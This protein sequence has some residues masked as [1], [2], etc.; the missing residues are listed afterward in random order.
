MDGFAQDDRYLYL[1]LEFVRGGELFTYL[2][3]VGK[4]ESDQAQYL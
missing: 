1:I 2:R 3:G 4:F